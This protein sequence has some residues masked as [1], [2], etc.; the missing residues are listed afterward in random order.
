MDPDNIHFDNEGLQPDS[1]DDGPILPLGRKSVVEAA[2]NIAAG[3]TP[4]GIT[5][6]SHSA[7]SSAKK[8]SLQGM[9]SFDHS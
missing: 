4:T 9:E 3:S 1:D 8:A 2:S 5:G 7:H 6:S